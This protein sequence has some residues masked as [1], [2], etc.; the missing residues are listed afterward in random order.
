MIKVA[1]AFSGGLAAPEFSLKYEKIEHEVV[2][3]C[4]FD[5]YARKQYLKFHGE[6]ESEFYDD[7]QTLDASKYK[8]DI[9]LYVWGSPCQDLSLAGKRKGLAGER[10]GLFHHGLR[11][12][13][14][15]RPKVFI[16]ENVKGLLS[17]NDGADFDLVLKSFRD[18]GYHCTW[19]VM[20]TKDYGAPQNRERVFVVGFLDGDEYMKFNFED[21]HPLELRLKDMLE[22]EVDEK[23]Y[24]S[25]KLVDGF[26]RKNDRYERGGKAEGF[27]LK[28]KSKYEVASCLT[29]GYYKCSASDNYIKE[30]ELQKVGDLDIKGNECIKRV[31]SKDGICPAFITMGGGNREPKI[32]I[33]GNIYQSKHE[34]GNIYSSDGIICTLKCNGPRPN[35]KNQAPKILAMRGRNPSNP[36]SRKS[37][38]PT[39]QMLEY[40]ENGTSNCLTGVQ[41][42]NLVDINYRIRK[43]TPKECFKL[44]GVKEQDI[45]LCVSDSQAYKIAGNAISVNV[46]QSILRS[47]FKQEKS[48]SLLDFMEAGV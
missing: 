23:Y 47:L 44:Q 24:L 3:A 29:A 43:L 35:S 32:M 28:P 34:A 16:F 13:N 41:K 48:N 31:Y 39:E 45:D 21:K 36:K 30:P 8:D 37:G 26:K 2:F 19:Q 5:K 14:E 4:E 10:S 20:N 1:T 25:D 42:D 15:M 9:D 33:K 27:T 40:N 22:D 17:S 6:P 18:S 38:L 46:M 11:I 12:L 7:V